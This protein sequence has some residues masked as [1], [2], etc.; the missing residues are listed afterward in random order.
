LGQL[1]ADFQKEEKLRKAIFGNAGTIIAFKVGPDDAEFLEKEFYP[2]FEK[3]DLIN[4]DKHHIYLKLAIDGKTSKPFSGLTLSPFFKFERQGNKDKI[5]EG[6]RMRYAIK[7]KGIEG[8][9]GRWGGEKK[10]ININ[11]QCFI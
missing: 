9:I 4:Q 1:G 5:I 2:D 10:N 11:Q 3:E 7:R 8:K 6:S